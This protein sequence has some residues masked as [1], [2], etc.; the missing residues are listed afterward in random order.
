MVAVD[1]GRDE[2]ARSL[3]RQNFP[4]YRELGDLRGTGENLCRSAHAL[5]AVGRA[6]TA[7]QLLG[8]SE[9]VFEGIGAKPPWLARVNDETL[10][11]I[12]EQLDEAAIAEA[13]EQGRTLNVDEAVALALDSL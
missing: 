2:E 7:A 4:M 3:L 1:D 10:A 12:R 13:W 6:E 9:A 8:G 11:A 5:A